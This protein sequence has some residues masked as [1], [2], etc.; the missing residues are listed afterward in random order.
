MYNKRV[1]IQRPPV[2][3]K[4]QFDKEEV[5]ASEFKSLKALALAADVTELFEDESG[6]LLAITRQQQGYHDIHV[7]YLAFLF[8]DGIAYR[9]EE[10]FFHTFRLKRVKDKVLHYSLKDI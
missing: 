1:F 5:R 10:S 6:N 7:F 8:E 3:F 9:Q 2:A 4:T